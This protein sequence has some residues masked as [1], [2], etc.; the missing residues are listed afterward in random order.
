MLWRC[1]LHHGEELVLAVK[2]ARPIVADIFGTLHLVGMKNGQR[3]ALFL[4]K[5][6]RI[7]HLRARQAGRIRQYGHHAVAQ[8][9]VRSPGQEA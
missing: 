9:A 7:A 3:N 2:A 5:G 6:N 1:C 4:G 8:F